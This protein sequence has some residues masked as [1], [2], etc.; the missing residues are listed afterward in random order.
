MHSIDSIKDNS[1]FPLSAIHFRLIQ[2]LIT[3]GL[4]LSIVGGSNSINS[5]GTF[6]VQTISKVAIIIFI[7]AYVAL[8]LTA[9]LASSKLHHAESGEKRLLLAVI[10][11]LPFIIVRLV[12]S[13]LAALTDFHEF[14]LLTGSVAIFAV[15]AVA[16]EFAVILI[17]LVTG[18]K[19]NAIDASQRGPIMS[20]PW[21]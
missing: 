16:M 6:K 4:I 9:L 7:V 2:L 19:T 15:M 11:A 10:L 3:I 21:K 12:Y 5:D 17:Y 20:R 14:N 18:W 8:A 13:T 1:T